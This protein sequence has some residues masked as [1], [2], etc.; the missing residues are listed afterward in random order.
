MAPRVLGVV[1]FSVLELPLIPTPFCAGLQWFWLYFTGQQKTRKPLLAAGLMYLL[2]LPCTT[3][4][5]RRRE[6]NPRP[7]ILPSRIYMLSSGL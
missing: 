7:Q 2:G 4:W 5:W 1:A 3:K 6:S